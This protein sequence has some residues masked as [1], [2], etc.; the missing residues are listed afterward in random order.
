MSVNVLFITSL[1]IYLFPR[2]Q[3]VTDIC[4]ELHR[5]AL[6]MGQLSPMAAVNLTCFYSEIAGCDYYIML[7]VESCF[8]EVIR[9]EKGKAH[10][11]TQLVMIFL[12]FSFVGVN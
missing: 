7:T 2:K 3:Y 6:R 12:F 11:T 4:M 9:R 10:F 8:P 5:T 1:S